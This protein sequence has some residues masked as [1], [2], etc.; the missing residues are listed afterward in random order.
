V[1][2]SPL[3]FSRAFWPI[4]GRFLAVFSMLHPQSMAVID[5]AKSAM[6]RSGP[7]PLS[8]RAGRASVIELG[9]AAL[10]LWLK[11]RTRSALYGFWVLQVSRSNPRPGTFP[12]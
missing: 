3:N 10:P 1:N 5:Q 4:S 6:L 2:R 8:L 7:L 9:F 11:V 12:C